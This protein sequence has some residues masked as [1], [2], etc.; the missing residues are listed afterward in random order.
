MSFLID[1]NTKLLVQGITGKEGMKATKEMLDYGTKVLAGV[2]P[3]K[4]GQQVEGVPVYNTVKEALKK[5][6]EINATLIYVPPLGAKDAAIEAI[7]NGI[8]LA[9]IFTEKIPVLDTA[10]IY[11]YAKRNEARVIGPSSVGIIS[12]GKAKIGSIGGANPDRVFAKGNIALLSKSGGMSSELAWILKQAGLGVSTVVGLGGDM[13]S[14]TTFADLLQMIK[15]DHETKALVIFG[16]IGGTY[17]QELAQK[18]KEINFK[19]PTVAFISG[20]FAETV[21]SDITLGHAGAIISEAGSGS[22]KEKKE[23]L[24]AAGVKIAEIPDDIPLL[25]K[26]ALAQ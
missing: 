13:I 10:Q 11:A 4:G 24:K 7:S 15:D 17:E 8:K 25:I 18:M 16:E 19:K 23:A 6:P 22:S 1:K 2:T 12:P 20:V 21:K 14:C 9:A 5:F 26:K 3:G